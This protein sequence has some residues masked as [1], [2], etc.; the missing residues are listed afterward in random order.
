MKDIADKA[1]TAPHLLFVCVH[2]TGRSQMAEAFV[3]K[4]SQGKVIAESAGTQPSDKLNPV[5]VQA[6]REK[7]IDITGH[8]PKLMSNEMIQRANHIF[9]M[10]CFNE[11]ECPAVILK[12]STDWGLEDPH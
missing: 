11:T 7:G 10:G 5:V 9:T 3:R 12:K 8:H 4:L 6:M 2:N 1:T